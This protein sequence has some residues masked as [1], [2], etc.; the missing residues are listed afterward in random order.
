MFKQIFTVM[1]LVASMSLATAKAAPALPS[2][3]PIDLTVAAEK[4][5]NSVVYIKVT[6]NAKTQT[7]QYFDPLKISSAIS[8]DAG[9]ATA[10]TA[11]NS[12]KLKRPSAPARVRALF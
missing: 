12:V 6:T 10:A 8:S 4:A 11:T 2:S 3:Q 9:K 7:G 5:V 1:A